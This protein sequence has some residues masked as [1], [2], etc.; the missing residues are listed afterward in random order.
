MAKVYRAAVIGCGA[1]GGL[2]DSLRNWAPG[3]PAL[4]HAGAYRSHPQ[5]V[6]VAA[7]D[8]DA[9]RRE[10]FA[11]FW[12]VP[13]CY[14]DHRI[15]LQKEDID[16]LSICTPAAQ[17]VV[18]LEE[19][20]SQGVAAIFC[21]KPLAL[22]LDGAL[23]ALEVVAERRTVLAVNYG[24]RWNPTIDELARD[25]RGGRWGTVKRVSALYPGGIMGGG[26]HAL[27]LIHWLV[28]PIT[29]VKALAAAD[30]DDPDPPIDAYCRI[31]SDVPCIVQTGDPSDFSLLE[32][33]LMTTKGRIQLTANGRR[34][35]IFLASPDVHFPSYRL[36]SSE[37]QIQPTQWE[38]CMVRA[39]ED[40]VS[41][42][43]TGRQPRCGGAE[44]IEALRVATAIRL[45][46]IEGEREVALSSV[47]GKLPTA[48][49]RGV[50]R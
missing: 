7:A 4:S 32:L 13:S 29:S 6:L 20:A 17:H 9:L 1:I 45:S 49:K 36:L 42:L 50:I 15:M 12:S 44:A 43:E 11:R 24:R 10:S 14:G 40:L 35:E 23:Q 5:V 47:A 8:P 22:D 21:E 3:L 41:C 2:N 18:L 28:G 26:T 39:V 27:D 16:I 33:D 30:P 46:S 38:G 34:I 31:G 25:L 37:A 48:N 19:S